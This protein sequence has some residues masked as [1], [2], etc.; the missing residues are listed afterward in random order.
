MISGNCVLE[1]TLKGGKLAVT[2]EIG[3]P[4]HSSPAQVINHARL[5][6][7]DVTAANVTDCQTAVVRM[8]SIA[9]GVHVLSSGL[10]PIV[11]MTCRDRNRIAIQS[12][13]LGAYSLGIRNLL[14]LTGDHQ[15]FGNHPSSKNVYDLDSIQMVQLVR[16]MRDEKNFFSGEELKE[17]EPRFFIGAVANPFADPFEFRVDRLEKKINAGAEFIQ[18]QCIYDLERFSRFMEMCVE[19]GLHE[20]AYIL[21]GVGPLRNLRVAKYIQANVSGMI[22][23]DEI[24]QRLKNAEDQEVE[25]IS[26]CIEQIK[27]IKDHIRGISGFHIMAIARE[28]IVPHIV[29]QAGISP[30]ME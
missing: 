29:R 12:D 26:I 21:A 19:R 22:I 17:Y 18:T 6:K 20:R 25:G 5:L 14:C 7:G 30:H 4:K 10:E 16:R 2:A 28:E 15:M 8:S 27:Y 11:Q 23:P 13:L 1:E 3:P 24:I 9:A